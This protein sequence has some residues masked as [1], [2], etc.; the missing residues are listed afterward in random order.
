MANKKVTKK[1]NKS[2]Q[3]NKISKK[4][5]KPANAKVAKEKKPVKKAK[6]KLGGSEAGY[7]GIDQNG[8]SYLVKTGLTLSL[9]A[10]MVKFTKEAEQAKDL[11]AGQEI[12]DLETKNLATTAVANKAKAEKEVLNKASWIV[13]TFFRVTGAE[14]KVEPEAQNPLAKEESEKK[15]K[16]SK[17][18]PS[19]HLYNAFQ[20]F[21]GTESGK[22]LLSK[23]SLTIEDTHALYTGIIESA[24]QNQNI[25]KNILGTAVL[26][27]L[28]NNTL[29]QTWVNDFQEQTLGLKPEKVP[30]AKLFHQGQGVPVIGSKMISAEIESKIPIENLADILVSCYLPAG[31]KASD[32][33]DAVQIANGKITAS[34]DVK[35]QDIDSLNQIHTEINLK[36]G[37]EALKE[38]LFKF[39]GLFSAILLRLIM[40][41][42]ADLGPDNM[43][44]IDN[45]IVDIDV[46][47]CRANREQNKPAYDKISIQQGWGETI[48]N[49]ASSVGNLLDPFTFSS[50]Y[51]DGAAMK[52]LK[53]K[54]TFKAEN[55]LLH[56]HIISVIKETIGHKAEQEVKQV[57]KYMSEHNPNMDTIKT[58]TY[59]IAALIT[60]NLRP[61]PENIE[62]MANR[63]ASVFFENAKEKA[64]QAQTRIDIEEADK[65]VRSQN[66]SV[67]A[68]VLGT[69][70]NTT[71]TSATPVT[72]SKGDIVR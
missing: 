62:K 44:V 28:V 13:D 3:K 67:S 7:I 11:L 23:P 64:A 30:V 48:S 47:G 18:V 24:E 49:P 29:A 65:A 38:K 32:V 54:N 58:L 6:E 35:Q 14:E 61:D 66:I 19:K 4:D 37:D 55:G 60:K 71:I 68:T 72:N 17:T 21:L 1:P 36:T 31:K 5:K 20:K 22:L 10:Q 27:D 33:K 59:N 50:R 46:T 51:I 42:T 63:N 16:E 9:L 39:D 57:I 53:E 56:D 25:I 34:N 45:K 69:G 52:T 40:G 2:V 26:S 12:R 41:E 43:L 15:F 8:A 70:P